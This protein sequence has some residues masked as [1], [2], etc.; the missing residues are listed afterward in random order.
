MK[1]VFICVAVLLVII[2]MIQAT[3]GNAEN[4]AKSEALSEYWTEDS[5]A[6]RELIDYV[7]DVTDEESENFIP[8]EDQ[9]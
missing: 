7:N 8:E 3:K 9:K 4:A 2:G 5:E 1:A 6:A